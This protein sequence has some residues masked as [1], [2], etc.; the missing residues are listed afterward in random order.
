[1]YSKILVPLDASP[2]SEKVLPFARFMANGLKIP[3]ELLRVIDFHVTEASCAPEHGR[4]LDVVA[5]E[6]KDDGLNYLRSIAKSF[7]DGSAVHCSTQIGDP[8]EV[9][10]DRAES[11]SGT[12]V[13]MSTHGRSG[14][15]RWLLGSVADKVLHATASPLVLV[16]A[17]GSKS[18]AAGESILTTMLVPLDGPGLSELVLPHVT[19]LARTLNLEVVVVRAPF[20]PVSAYAASEYEA[21]F[22]EVAKA[23][24]DECRKY[25]EQKV[26]QLQ[27]GG[28]RKVSYV[29][30][31]GDAATEIIDMA[32]TTP[33]NL[34]AMSTHGN[35]GVGRWLL[36]SVTDRVV[37]Y[38]GDPVLVI[39]APRSD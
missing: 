25:L 23:R 35:S 30:L 29:L 14:A 9:I 24:V 33:D 16:R 27:A 26:E 3:V 5:S 7:A 10:V 34:V 37:R 38:S 2:L 28:I 15:Q 22:Q 39:R 18:D 32:R 6:M 36:G 12:L 1:M 19:V 11:Q 20:V 31:N 8:A 4:Y 21:S 17:K 13:L